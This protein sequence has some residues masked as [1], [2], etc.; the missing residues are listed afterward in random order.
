M[1]FLYSFSSMYTDNVTSPPPSSFISSVTRNSCM[2]VC[3]VSFWYLCHSALRAETFSA[4]SVNRIDPS[5]IARK[6]FPN[7]RTASLKAL[8]NASRLLLLRRTIHV[9]TIIAPPVILRK[10]QTGVTTVKNLEIIGFTLAASGLD[11][12]S[13]ARQRNKRWGRVG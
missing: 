7:G 8:T 4:W 1:A 2:S 6:Q 13:G 5:L 11:R 12:K 10:V 9:V 3:R